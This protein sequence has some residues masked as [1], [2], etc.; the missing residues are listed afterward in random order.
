MTPPTHSEL[1]LSIAIIGALLA[2]VVAVVSIINAF[3]RK[4]SIEAEFSTKSECEKCRDKMQLDLNALRQQVNGGVSRIEFDQFRTSVTN[5][6]GELR[7][8]V[9]AGNTELVRAISD[10]KTEIL[11]TEER[12]VSDLHKRLNQ[13]E[14]DLTRLDERSKL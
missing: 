14:R 9:Q 6:L 3:R 11:T 2:I 8:M 1:G 4:P 10:M 12:R 13:H 5:T 7:G